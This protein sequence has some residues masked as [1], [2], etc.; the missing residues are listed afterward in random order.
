M[1]AFESTI[2]PVLTV[3]N[4]AQAVT[5]YHRAFGAQ[6]I[7]RTTYPNGRIVAE[8]AIGTARFRVADESP[9]AANLS[10]QSSH[11][12]WIVAESC[13]QRRYSGSGAGAKTRRARS[14]SRK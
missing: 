1:D 2:T 9:E 3:R 6:E 7:S 13:T 12:A 14:R 11:M 5:F 4:A 10:L 8:I